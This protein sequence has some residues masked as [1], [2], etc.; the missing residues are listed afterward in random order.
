[1]GATSGYFARDVKFYFINPLGYQSWVAIRC[2]QW[3]EWSDW[4]GLIGRAETRLT[5]YSHPG[6]LY[7]PRPV[8]HS[9][10]ES[11]FDS[12]GLWK[13][14]RVPFIR[15]GVYCSFYGQILSDEQSVPAVWPFPEP[16]RLA[17][18]TLGGVFSSL[19]SI[20]VQHRLG[21]PG[22]YT[23]RPGTITWNLSPFLGASGVRIV[24]DRT[25]SG[26]PAR[27]G[28]A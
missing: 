4:L 14:N 10:A 23:T 24:G 1:M 25:P 21:N 28:G 13:S 27:A 11:P 8:V 16:P 26:W 18:G 2:A 5:G 9:R 22:S 7:D 6:P 20:V 19:H 15:A 3:Q 17:A 12:F